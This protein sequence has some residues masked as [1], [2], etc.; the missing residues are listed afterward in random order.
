MIASVRGARP[1]VRTRWAVVLLLL[2]HVLERSVWCADK[3]TGTLLVKDALTGLSQSVAVE[4]KLIGK[5]MLGDVDLAGEPLERSQKGEIAAKAMTAGHQR[6]V[7]QYTPNMRGMA[8]LTVRV[9][10]SP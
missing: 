4:A 3:V 5:G 9:A 7:F 10:E 6:A 8:T 1:A 2:L